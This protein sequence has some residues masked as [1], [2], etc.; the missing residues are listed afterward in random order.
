MIYLFQGQESKVQEI[1]NQLN[2]QR[3]N[4]NDITQYLK[5]VSK[6]KELR[7]DIEAQIYIAEEFLNLGL[8]DEAETLCKRLMRRRPNDMN[9]QA[10]HVKI[11]NT[12]IEQNTDSLTP[13]ERN[14]RV[15]ER[16]VKNVE[17]KITGLQPLIQLLS[18]ML[19]KSLLNEQQLLA[20]KDVILLSSKPSQGVKTTIKAFFEQ[21]Y[22]YKLINKKE[23]EVIDLAQ[24]GHEGSNMLHSFLLDMYHAFHH[25]SQVTVF[26]NIDQCPQ[27]LYLQM[28]QLV[29]EGCIKLDGRYSY[30]NG[31]LQKVE[32]VLISE[33]FNA[34]EAKEQF[35]IFHTNRTLDDALKIF[36]STSQAKIKTLYEIES[37]SNDESLKLFKMFFDHYL[38]L[39]RNNLGIDLSIDLQTFQSIASSTFKAGGAVSLNDFA[40]QVFEKINDYFIQ[41]VDQVKD[42]WELVY[43]MEKVCIK[44]E[45]NHIPLFMPQGKGKSLQKI[46][47]EIASLIGLEEVKQ[48]LMELKFYLENRTKRIER[49]LDSDLI[50]MHI[51]FKGNPGTGK[52]MVARKL[53]QYL[54]AIDYLSEG[55]LV[56]VDRSGL[57]GEYIGHT[58][59]KTMGK[60]EA[61]MGGVLFIDEAYALARGGEN[62]FGQE[63][64]DTL[65]KAMDDYRGKFV[66]IFAGYPEEMDELM[67]MNPGLQSRISHN[68]FFSDYS[69]A[70]LI[71]IATLVAN[72]QG[73]TIDSKVKE[74]LP[75]YFERYQ[76]KGKTDSGNGRLARRIVEEAITKQSVRLMQNDTLTEDD[77]NVLIMDDFGLE[78]EEPFDLEQALQPI[79]GLDHVKEMVRTLYRQ[80]L[81]NKKRKEMNPVFN[82]EQSLNFIF[83]GNPGTGKTTIARV[84]ADL[85]KS[86]D[87]IKRGHLVEVSRSDLVSGYIGQTAI[88]TE[89][90]FRKALGGV[91][92]IDEA[93]SLAQ[94][95]EN[96]FGQEAIDTLIKLIE[97]YR[98]NIVVI[99]A[100]YEQSMENFLAMNE[101][102]HSRFTKTLHFKDYT[103]E[104]LFAIALKVIADSGFHLNEAG[105]HALKDYIFEYCVHVDGNGRFIRNMIEELIRIQS[106]SIFM[107]EEDA[108]LTI[109]EKD[110]LT[111]ITKNQHT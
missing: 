12:T 65:V 94:G 84:I 3:D 56:E 28:N 15:V 66:V 109:T 76:I 85:F 29:S 60:V 31:T 90:V 92:F 103:T 49:G 51:L 106:D 35:L 10:L 98:G 108:L 25:D 26:K 22:S 64:I 30:R 21:A 23:I 91:L 105:N 24:Y 7:Q 42:Q 45:Q 62:D 77:L 104:E 50:S 93:Y 32:G 38:K 73:Y 69:T 18:N 101:G 4:N 37:L 33:S 41:H 53:A 83:T 111:Y 97:D 70:Q 34:I 86:I 54:K 75:S 59:T 36:T 55:Q 63:A 74:M 102:I 61:A 100:G 6:S 57:V 68:F 95:G 11:R 20:Y 9:V 5:D 82:H 43:D 96:D 1:K 16:I 110:V 107:D 87:I 47:E 79:I 27:D 8:V 14:R 71:E 99:L 72:N 52:T 39:S 89:K 78:E 81:I 19:Q 58:A 13:L 44:N 80:E 2:V 46:E 17:Q 40:Y 67:E 88:K 48:S